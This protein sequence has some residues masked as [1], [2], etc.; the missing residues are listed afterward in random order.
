[1]NVKNTENRLQ[2]V[3]SECDD[4]RNEMR[5]LETGNIILKLFVVNEK[6][7]FENFWLRFETNYGCQQRVGETA[8][9]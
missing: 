4:L 2:F 7:I 3:Q 1:M 8:E 9:R 6:I 5:G